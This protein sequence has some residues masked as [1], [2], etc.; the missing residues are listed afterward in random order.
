M[1]KNAFKHLYTVECGNACVSECVLKT[2]ACRGLRVGPSK[3]RTITLTAEN[4]P[5]SKNN[6]SSNDAN[7]KNTTATKA[8]TRTTTSCLVTLQTSSLILW[9]RGLRPPLLAVIQQHCDQQQCQQQ[10][11]M[12]PNDNRDMNINQNIEQTPTFKR[13]TTTITRRT[14]RSR[15]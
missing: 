5:Q 13:E 11:G 2:L 15:Q 8:K 9:E 7:M 1:S 12:N 6:M 4:T 3:C 10:Q 14:T